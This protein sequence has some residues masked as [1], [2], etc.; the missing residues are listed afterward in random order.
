MKAMQQGVNAIFTGLNHDLSELRT[1]VYPFSDAY[2]RF[3]ETGPASR[4]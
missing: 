3:A 2:R 4:N 1:R